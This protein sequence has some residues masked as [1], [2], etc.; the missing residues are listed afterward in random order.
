MGEGAAR[1]VRIRMHVER[2]S[3]ARGMRMAGGGGACAPSRAERGGEE[4]DGWA[5]ARKK[6][7]TSLK[8]ETKVFPGSKSHQIFT[9]D[10]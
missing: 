2:G 7:E 4:A 10:R 1:L 9:R 6:K 8:F 3:L 5:Q